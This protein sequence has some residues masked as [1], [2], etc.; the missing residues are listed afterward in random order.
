M[1]FRETLYCA[2]ISFFVVFSLSKLSVYCMDWLLSFSDPYTHERLI[3]PL[4][5]VSALTS[6]TWF[7]MYSRK[8][9][10][11]RQVLLRYALAFVTVL[12]VTFGVLGYTCHLYGWDLSSRLYVSVFF[13]TLMV[14]AIIITIPV[15]HSKSIADQCNRGL[16]EQR[17]ELNNCD[18]N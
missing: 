17:Q 11:S 5:L 16:S 13:S 2:L 3:I 7:L 6:L 9:L 18:D 15:L 4:L 10:T 8:P 14:F 1:T 12:L